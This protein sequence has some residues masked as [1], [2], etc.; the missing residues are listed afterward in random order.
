VC[1]EGIHA[2]SVGILNRIEVRVDSGEGHQQTALQ[3]ALMACGVKSLMPGAKVA[4]MTMHRMRNA[5]TYHSPLPP[6]SAS[7]ADSSLPALEIMVRAAS[8]FLMN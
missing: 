8:A 6:V 1:Y 4:I 7:Q 3:V 5:K 2:L